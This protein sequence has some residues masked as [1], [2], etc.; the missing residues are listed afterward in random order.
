M[1]DKS[2]LHCLDSIPAVISMKNPGV[3]N[4]QLREFVTVKE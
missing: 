2:I 1:C 4:Y 3:K